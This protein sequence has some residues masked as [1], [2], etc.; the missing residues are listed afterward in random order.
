MMQIKFHPESMAQRVMLIVPDFLEQKPAKGTSQGFTQNFLEELVR[1]VKSY[2]AVLNFRSRE[3]RPEG[4]KP[5]VNDNDHDYHIL[6]LKEVD[7]CVAIF[8]SPHR[9]DLA[10][11]LTAKAVE[12]TRNILVLT[13]RPA[14]DSLP[15]WLYSAVVK[16][17][18][19]EFNHSV[20]KFQNVQEARKVSILIA[21]ALC[22]ICGLT[23]THPAVQFLEAQQ[24]IEESRPVTTSVSTLRR[25]SQ[26]QANLTK[27]AVPVEEGVS[28][29]MEMPPGGMTSRLA[30]AGASG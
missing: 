27:V 5:T 6:A 23:G 28:E 11:H 14:E 24:R 17:Y 3:V 22:R 8:A 29:P 7:L 12:L 15:P 10:A 19:I 30:F 20:P 4:W 1:A 16:G 13:P 21:N 25:L 26:Q 18:T 2:A 9:Q